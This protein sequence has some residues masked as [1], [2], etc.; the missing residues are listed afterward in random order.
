LANETRKQIA[1]GRKQRFERGKETFSATNALESRKEMFDFALVWLVGSQ[2]FMR[3]HDKLIQGYNVLQSLSELFRNG[4][5]EP[6][7]IILVLSTTVGREG[8]TITKRHDIEAAAKF[9]VGNHSSLAHVDDEVSFGWLWR[10]TMLRL[11]E[12]PEEQ[13]AIDDRQ[14]DLPMPPQMTPL[15]KEKAKQ[16]RDRHVKHYINLLND[17]TPHVDFDNGDSALSL[18]RERYLRGDFEKRD[19]ESIFRDSQVGTNLIIAGLMRRRGSVSP[20]HFDGLKIDTQSGIRGLK[21]I[22]SEFGEMTI[23]DDDA[24]TASWLWKEAM[25]R[26]S[27]TAPKGK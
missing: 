5:F 7:E 9:F 24:F 8:H 26:M 13:Q 27:K 19:I 22:V 17:N 18:L 14:H 15:Q 12:D 25:L 11:K 6:D 10:E 21:Q 3:N 20:S 16:E 23:N 1:R 4:Q 2:E